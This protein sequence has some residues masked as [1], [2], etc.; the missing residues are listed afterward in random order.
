[1]HY[2]CCNGYKMLV[3]KTKMRP[4]GKLNVDGGIALI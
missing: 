3:K 1:V 4:L 2:I